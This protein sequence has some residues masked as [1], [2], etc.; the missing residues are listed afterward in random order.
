MSGKG[1]SLMASR[2]APCTSL[3]TMTSLVLATVCDGEVCRRVVIELRGVVREDGSWV[4]SFHDPDDP[5]RGDSVGGECVAMAR[6]L[7]E[8]WRRMVAVSARVE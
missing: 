6:A 3:A 8:N 2:V 5:L 7:R 4:L 1:Q